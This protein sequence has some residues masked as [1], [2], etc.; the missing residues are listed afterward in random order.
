MDSDKMY[1]IEKIDNNLVIA[2]DLETKEQIT[3]SQK[4]FT[5]SIKEGTMFVIKNNKII[6]QE[7]LEEERRKLLRERMVRLKRH[8]QK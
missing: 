3:L 2:E 5:F 6:K 8:E 7:K 4:D 1:A